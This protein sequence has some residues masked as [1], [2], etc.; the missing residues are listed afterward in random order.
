MDVKYTVLLYS[1]YSQ[2]C[3]K[4]INTIGEQSFDF[5]TLT[6][7]NT[8]CVDNEDIRNQIVNSKNIDIKMVPCILIIYNSGSVEKYEGNDA[9]R[10]TENIIKQHQPPPIQ[11]PPP[12]PIQ[13]PNQQPTPN[14]Q[15][16]PLYSSVEEQGTPIEACFE[17]GEHIEYDEEIF[18]PKKASLRSGPGSYDNNVDFGK[19][20]KSSKITR[21][22]KTG[23][24]EMPGRKGK[25][26]IMA[27]AMEMQKLREKE[28][29]GNRNK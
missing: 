29:P 2:F 22:I 16:P 10:W 5:A 9:F 21:G 8:V 23:T 28:D 20:A 17:E 11:Q 19:K 15:Q 3:K 18:P 25:G 26:D 14:E 6:R 4:L 12:Q 1:K 7:L 27:V 13:Q 24:S